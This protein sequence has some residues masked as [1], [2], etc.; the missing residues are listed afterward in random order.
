[1]GHITITIA[2]DNDAFHTDEGEHSPAQEVAR[3]LRKLADDIDTTGDTDQPLID[4][5]GNRV[6]TSSSN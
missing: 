2:T 1:M 3:I 6:G 5:N 4:T